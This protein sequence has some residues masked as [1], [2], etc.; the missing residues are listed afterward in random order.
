MSFHNFKRRRS[1]LARPKDIFRQLLESQSIGFP[2][3]SMYG[4]LAWL[5]ARLWI[6]LFFAKFRWM[7]CW[8]QQQQRVL[9]FAHS[10]LYHLQT[11]CFAH[12]QLG[13]SR[14]P[15]FWG[16]CCAGVNFNRKAPA[17]E[18]IE[19]VARAACFQLCDS[20]DFNFINSR[21]TPKL[22]WGNGFR[23]GNVKWNGAGAVCCVLCVVG[24][25]EASEG[26]SN[27]AALAALQ[28][29]ALLNISFLAAYLS[30]SNA[31][32]ANFVEYFQVRPPN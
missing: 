22:G 20:S 27:L 32:K 30:T 18:A 16:P 6:D 7:L 28:L 21:R 4:I 17:W 31:S 8:K 10:C 3:I 14:T 2:Y 29:F 19:M 25:H 11:V 23:I 1:Q 24:G 12:T 9:A 15:P 26:L 5:K 13:V